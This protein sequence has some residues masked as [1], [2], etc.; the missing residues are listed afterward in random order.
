MLVKYSS[1]NSGGSWWLSDDDWKALE[2]AGWEID[3]GDVYFCHSKYSF[4]KKPDGKPE[5]CSSEDVCPGHRRADSAEEAEKYRWLKSLA[6]SARKET[7]SIRD[8][9]LEFE[10]VTG[11][12][13]SD[14]GCNCCGPPHSFSW[15]G[16]YCSGESCLQYLYDD[17]PSS[18]REA[19]EL[20]K[21]HKDGK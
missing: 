8:L 3:W 14:E 10:R 1:N 9:L 5:P 7:D 19:V 2:V 13:V 20:L 15:D 4:G 12:S 18:F 17:V 11:Q 6:R 21:S 16:G